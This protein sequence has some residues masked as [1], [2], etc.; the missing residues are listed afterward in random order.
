M[1]NLDIRSIEELRQQEAPVVVVDRNGFIDYVNQAFEQA[2]G[3]SA[4]EIRGQALTL[5]IP[6][7]L[8]DAHHLGFSRFLET[9]R[10]SLLRRPLGLRARDRQG[11]EFEAEHYIVAERQ[12]GGWVFGALIR[13]LEGS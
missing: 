13:P 4:A 9:G 11:R 3:W 1:S 10:G 5:I 12:N 2:F 7:H 6:E 8:H